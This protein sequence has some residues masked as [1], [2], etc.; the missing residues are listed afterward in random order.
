MRD[1]L[2]DP[3]LGRIRGEAARPRHTRQRRMDRA[4]AGFV[5]DVEGR[6]ARRLQWVIDGRAALG[7]FETNT[8]LSWESVSA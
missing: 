6:P 1:S 2:S 7:R 4:L 3:L 5:G 8:A